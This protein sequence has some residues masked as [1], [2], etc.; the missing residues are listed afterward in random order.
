MNDV[1]SSAFASAGAVSQRHGDCHTYR[2]LS[3]MRVSDSRRTTRVGFSTP[4]RTS[5]RCCRE[6]YIQYSPNGA[7][8]T[9]NSLMTIAMPPA[10]AGQYNELHFM[11]C[12]SKRCHRP[13]TSNC[14]KNSKVKQVRLQVW[15][16]TT[17]AA[18]YQQIICVLNVHLP[19]A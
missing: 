5:S 9:K 15:F 3:F 12:H 4:A 14:N 2:P 16:H 7:Q 6:K 8:R 19:A 11:I 13:R 18:F 10:Q 17:A 1:C